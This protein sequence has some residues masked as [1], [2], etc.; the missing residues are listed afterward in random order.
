MSAA[1][2]PGV[3]VRIGWA[4]TNEMLG[5]SPAGQTGTIADGPYEPGTEFFVPLVGGGCG[6]L[7]MRERGWAVALDTGPRY[8]I[9]ERLLFPID[10]D[11]PE[12][13]ERRQ[14]RPEEC[15]A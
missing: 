6:V 15:G 12:Y 14:D 10:D 11:P 7:V 13:L 9:A 1:L 4:P 8:M 3:R 5:P 2:G